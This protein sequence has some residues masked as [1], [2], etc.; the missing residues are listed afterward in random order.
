MQTDQPVSGIRAIQGGDPV[1]LESN[2]NVC[3]VTD[4]QEDQDS[5]D[6]L[7][8]RVYAYGIGNG[9]TCITLSGIT[10]GI[11]GW[12]I[13][14]D[15]K[16]Y[17]L[18]HT[19]TWSAYGIERYISFK[20]ISDGTTLMEVTYEWMVRRLALQAAYKLSVAKLDQQIPVGSSIRV[21]YKR[22]LDNITIL[23]IDTD[24]VVL[25]TTTRL[26]ADGL[27]TTAL[28]VATTDVWPDNSASAT[29][30]GMSKAQD[31]YTHEQNF[32]KGVDAE[33]L[34]LTASSD[35]P[36]ER[37]FTPDAT[38]TTVDDGAGGAYHIGVDASGIGSIIASAFGDIV[39]FNPGDVPIFYDNT[40]TGF[41]AALAAA[42]TGAYIHVPAGEITGAHSIPADVTVGGHSLATIFSGVITCAG[43]LV[44]VQCEAD[45]ILSGDGAYF[46]FNPDGNTLTSHNFLVGGNVETIPAQKGTIIAGANEDAAIHYLETGGSGT[47]SVVVHL[48]EENHGVVDYDKTHVLDVDPA[49]PAGGAD[50]TPSAYCVCRIDPN[51]LPTG[52]IVTGIKVIVVLKVNMAGSLLGYDHEIVFWDGADATISENKASAVQIGTDYETRVYGGAADMWTIAGLDTAMI[53]SGDVAFACRYYRNPPGLL[54]LQVDVDFISVE[55]FGTANLE[56]VAGLDVIEGTWAVEP[57]D[58]LTGAGLEFNG[59]TGMLKIPAITPNPPLDVASAVMVTDFNADL[60]D[61]QHAAAFQ[62]V[63]SFPLVASLGGTGVAN[64]A[65]CTLTLPDAATTITGGGTLALGGFILTVPATGT[66][67]L[68]NRANSFTLINPLTTIAESWIGPSSTNGVYFKGGLVGV[69]LI[70]P[71]AK[72]HVEGDIRIS[73][74]SDPYL[75]IAEANSTTSY[76]EISDVSA[77]RTVIKK[78]AAAG[79]AYIDIDPVPSDGTAIAKIRLFRSTNTSGLAALEILLGNNS[80]TVNSL[81]AGTGDSYVCVNNGNFGI[82]DNTPDAKL[83]VAGD[84][85][86]DTDVRVGGGLYVGGVATNPATGTAYIKLGDAG[87]NTFPYLLTLNHATSDTPV[88]G[89]GSAIIYRGETSGAGAVEDVAQTQMMCQWVIADH[90]TRTAKWTLQ[91]I[92]TAARTVMIG[93]ASGTAPKVGFLGAAAVVRAAHIADATNAAD[94]I[95]R[96]N[97]ILVVLENLGFIATA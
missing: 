43:F 12:T 60:L 26:D 1:S 83:D 36:N 95:T 79:A 72:L 97:A 33:F 62:T 87:T 75:R 66:A 45:V 20:D 64:G 4:I 35:L 53:N 9:D 29:V 39:L 59:V 3:L 28:K 19:D 15:A 51:Q 96:A 58:I 68:L 81:L 92:D 69:G 86:I 73:E 57:G 77:D 30:G 65:S 25:E 89:F 56:Y 27:R 74:T 32:N 52:F 8:G 63:L 88:A 82:G 70:D 49:F 50:G 5:Y 42:A 94:V 47:T 93:E 40:S 54:W 84:A 91:V 22:I 23:D 17:Y 67:A 90:A 7:V 76:F 2:T 80:A 34:V 11:T 85:W 13:G 48:T 14:A 37:I 16:G 41:D 21:I 31:Y 24:L 10:I 46:I 61:G 38:L 44:N 18:Q 71:L 55:V 6:C 78:V